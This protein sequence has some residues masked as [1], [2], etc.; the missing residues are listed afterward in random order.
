MYCKCLCVLCYH[1][2]RH[3]TCKTSELGRARKFRKSKRWSSLFDLN[4][5]AL[6]TEDEE[7]LT[8]TKGCHWLSVKCCHP[9]SRDHRTFKGG[10]SRP[11]NVCWCKG[12]QHKGD[13]RALILQG[14][15]L[16]SVAQLASITWVMI[17]FSKTERSNIIYFNLTFLEVS[18]F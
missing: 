17:S 1:P 11:Q 13:K 7:E 2:C 4:S 6:C 18:Y 10:N 5:A 8:C 9:N 3:T 16:A 15:V 12:D 14:F